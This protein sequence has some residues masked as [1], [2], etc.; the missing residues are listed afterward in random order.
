[1]RHVRDA[2]GR[3]LCA[4]A[5]ARIERRLRCCGRRATLPLLKIDL[6]KLQNPILL[7]PAVDRSS[8]GK[9]RRS[10]TLRKDTLP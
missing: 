9:A 8:T 3:T 6:T 1:M 10:L 4:G 5:L 7:G 2:E